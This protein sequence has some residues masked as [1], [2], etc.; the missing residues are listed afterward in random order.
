LVANSPSQPV[1][2]T[3]IGSN[4]LTVTPPADTRILNRIIVHSL[5]IPIIIDQTVAA[6]GTNIVC[7]VFAS[8]KSIESGRQYNVTATGL[9]K[10]YVA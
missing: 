1:S 10:M 5:Q 8:S 2:L 4:D 7:K 6:A 3:A 9:D